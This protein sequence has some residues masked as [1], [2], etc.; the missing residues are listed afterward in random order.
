[1]RENSMASLVHELQKE[2]CTQMTVGLP[3]T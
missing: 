1:M 3:Q 2:L